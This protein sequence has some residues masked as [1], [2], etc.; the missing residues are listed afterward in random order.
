MIA[1]SVPRRVPRP[2]LN[3]NEEKQF[4]GWIFEEK[5]RSTVHYCDS[6][7]EMRNSAG[8]AQQEALSRRRSAG[9]APTILK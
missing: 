1:K 4:D 7:I 8:A 5:E 3:M 6:N 2:A 9:G